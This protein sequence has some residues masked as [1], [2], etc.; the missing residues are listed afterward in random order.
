MTRFRVGR[1][2]LRE[3]I[4]LEEQSCIAEMQRGSVG[5]LVVGHPYGKMIAESLCNYL[6]LFATK[7]ADFI[8][9]R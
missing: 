2:V 3:A 8:A 7:F 6:E 4:T 5:G 9:T 1:S